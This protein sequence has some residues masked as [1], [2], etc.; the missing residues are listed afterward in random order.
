M[1][2]H[3][4]NCVDQRLLVGH[5]QFC[6]V[7]VVRCMELTS[8]GREELNAPHRAA[9]QRWLRAHPGR[10][11]HIRFRRLHCLS[12]GDFSELG[13][14]ARFDLADA[15]LADPQL[16]ADLHQRPLGGAADPESAYDDPPLTRF[17]PTEPAF[18]HHLPV[19]L[20][21]FALGSSKLG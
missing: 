9:E 13:I 5:G 19:V 14:G 8:G 6:R 16:P 4:L 3:G 7:L 10:P 2:T 21:L 11:G 15:F 20:G 1:G 18:D 17:E 12:L